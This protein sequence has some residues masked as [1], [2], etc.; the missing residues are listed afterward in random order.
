MAIAT[1][2]SGGSAVKVPVPSF[3]P[4]DDQLLKFTR[5]SYSEQ[6]ND[7][8]AAAEMSLILN[9]Y[10]LSGH[11]DS[12]ANNL[13]NYLYGNGWWAHSANVMDGGNHCNHP[14]PTDAEKQN[15]LSVLQ[16]KRTL[17]LYIDEH[18]WRGDIAYIENGNGS[19]INDNSCY[20][21][22]QTIIH[23]NMGSTYTFYCF[24]TPESDPFGYTKESNREKFGD[25]IP[26]GG[27]STTAGG[28]SGGTS[29]AEPSGVSGGTNLSGLEFTSGKSYERQTARVEEGSHPELKTFYRINMSGAQF[30]RQVLAPYC[31]SKATGQGAYRLWFNDETSPDGAPGVKLFFKPDQ[32]S[33]IKNQLSDDLLENI[34]KTYEFSYGTGP[35]SSVKDFNPNYSGMVTSVT[36]GYEVDATTMNAITNDIMQVRY[37]K[38][39]DEK[40]PSTGDS[41][42]DGL[43]GAYRIG[44]SSYSLEE[45]QNRAA[46]LWYNMA[47]YGYTADM[48]V[49]GDPMIDVQSLC[50]V[51]ILTPLGIPHHSSGAYLIY[52]VTDSISGGTYETSMNMVRNA[53]DIGLD[54]SGGIEISLG[55]KD[56]IYVGEAGSLM[57]GTYNNVFGGGTSSAGGSNTSS[58]AN[59]G[60]SDISPKAANSIIQS[61]VD[62]AIGIAND[63]SYGYEWGARGIGA[64]GYDCSGLVTTA[65]LQAGLDF[66]TPSTHGMKSAMLA[67]GFVEHPELIHDCTNAQVGDVYLNE[68]VHTFMY[69]GNGKV[70]NASSNRDGVPGDSSGNEILITDWYEKNWTTVL[71][72]GG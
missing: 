71:R 24:P 2:G 18:D 47:P 4:S 26:A 51:T 45:I 42:Y 13:Y 43:Q 29:S 32:Y 70:V 46:N 5:I 54:D 34:D 57:T 52:H 28:S 9:K 21:Q 15:I 67:V 22:F 16:G 20:V 50:S 40:R 49:L 10:Y 44:D 23:N 11:T 41:T 58:T 48:T 61:A 55:S 62:W 19:S 33:N 36:G 39:S 25:G 31:R 60:N 56:T 30:I 17:P 35:E 6:G 68:Q 38:G 37:G 69:I 27:G 8:G 59:S 64:S 63:D 1:D 72:Y 14:N 65:Y 53:L 12:D 7:V 66:G 3:N